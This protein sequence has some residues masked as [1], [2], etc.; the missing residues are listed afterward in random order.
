MG[1]IKEP[2][3]LDRHFAFVSA[4]RPWNAIQR[5]MK[6]LNQA[7]NTSAVKAVIAGQQTTGREG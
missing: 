2:T 1:D 3:K 7:G 5:G 6:Q 4:N